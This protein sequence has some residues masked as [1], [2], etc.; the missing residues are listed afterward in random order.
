[1]RLGCACLA[2]LIAG[3]QEGQAQFMV[4]LDPRTVQ[5]FDQYAKGVEQELSKRWQGQR[6]FLSIEEK[7]EER[8]RVLA[9]GLFVEA[10][11]PENPVEISNGLIH[12][13]VGAVFI[14]NVTAMRVMRVLQDYDRHQHI[15]PSITQS[16]LL[17]RH[18]NHVSGYWRLERR[19]PL[20]TVALDLEQNAYYAQ[21]APGRWTCRAYAENILEVENAG[22]AQEEKLPPGE[23]H[24]FLWK[25]YAYWSLETVAGG[26]LAECRTVSLSRD[27]PG[28]LAWVIKPFVQKLPR[29]SLVSTLEHTRGACAQ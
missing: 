12:D 17:L 6:P 14:P 19:D 16:R 13:W 3:A 4:K 27:I 24:G 29:E 11:V 15:Y 5:E 9:G 23:G 28:A 25:F 2:V 7:A 22:T 21:V 26:V 10:A 8:E 1:M 20:L 18:A